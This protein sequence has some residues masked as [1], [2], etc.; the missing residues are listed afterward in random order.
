LEDLELTEIEAQVVANNL[1]VQS[2][3]AKKATAS[4]IFK[5]SDLATLKIPPKLRLTG[6]LLR[7]LVRVIWPV[8][9][10]VQYKLMSKHGELKG[11]FPGTEL[12]LTDSSS[13][14]TLGSGIHIQYPKNGPK[15]V[16]IALSKAVQLENQQ[17]TVA[18]A[19]RAGRKRKAN[20]LFNTNGNVNGANI[21]QGKRQRTAKALD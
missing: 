21:V 17:G 6:E 15:P 16:L 2:R 18:M 10:G 19:Q 13:E 12:N 7:L 3:I 8:R 9:G 20:T 11:L 14:T 4:T 1:N 5:A